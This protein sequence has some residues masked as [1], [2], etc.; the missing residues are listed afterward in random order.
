M[1][2]QTLFIDVSASLPP[3]LLLQKL[4]S[5]IQQPDSDPYLAESVTLAPN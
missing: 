3:D 5:L 4:K 2:A 1:K